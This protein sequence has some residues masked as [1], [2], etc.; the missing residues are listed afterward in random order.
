MLMGSYCGLDLNPDFYA[1]KS[2]AFTVE[3]S[4]YPLGFVELKTSYLPISL[5]NYN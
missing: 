1:C 3:L 4:R 5:V 2:S